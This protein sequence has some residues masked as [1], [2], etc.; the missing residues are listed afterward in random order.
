MQ[1]NIAAFGGD[2]A[3]V[4]LAGES[5][6]AACVSALSTSPLTEG[7]FV[8]VIGESSTATAPRP[9][10]SFRLLDEALASGRATRKRFGAATL[11]ELR[12]LPA[13][14]LAAAMDTEHHMTV[15]GYALTKTPYEAYRAGENHERAQLQGCNAQ[16]GTPFVLLGMA[17]LKN[18]A[19]KIRA[20]FGDYADEV[21]ALY[22]ASTDQEAKE[23]WIDI[24]SAWYF[25]YGHYCW[26]RQAGAQELPVYGYYFTKT[27]GRLGAW[28][29]G[30]EVYCYGNIPGGSKLYD[31]GDRELSELFS[32][33]FVNFARTG[34]PNGEGLPLWEPTR[35]GTRVLEI[36][37]SV[38]MREERYL[39]LYAILDRMQG[40]GSEEG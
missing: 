11:A 22:P 32:S 27:N 31:A 35:D 28:H 6:G 4:T 36:G 29:S 23:N 18:Y 34:D 12:A 10:H 9:A 7:L 40:F 16:E 3:N 5:A 25:T 15:D 38:Y 21:L 24:Y 13:E 19:D 8:R 14:K 30:E 37:E 17:K 39:P 20:L 26:A 1:K 33:Y 2:P